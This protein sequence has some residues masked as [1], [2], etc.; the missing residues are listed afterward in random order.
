MVRIAATLILPGETLN[1]R[2]HAGSS[3]PRVDLRLVLRLSCSAVPK[4]LTSPETVRP[5]STMVAGVETTSSPDWRG[6][7]GGMRGGGGVGGGEGG[8]AGGGGEGGGG[9]GGGGD[10]GSGGKGGEGGGGKGG[11]GEGDGG[12]GDGG[13]GQSPPMFRLLM[14]KG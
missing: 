8:G 9:E 14:V 13:D 11:G 6:E 12:G 4:V 1:A 10:G 2:M 3:H 7:K 5:T